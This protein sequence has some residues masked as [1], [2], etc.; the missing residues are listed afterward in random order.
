MTAWILFYFSS[1]I[2]HLYAGL[3][4]AGLSGGF[5]EAPVLTYVAEVTQ[6][7]FRGMLSATGSTFSILGVFS[8]VKKNKQNNK[9][10]IFT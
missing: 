1:N 3:C 6:P 2:Y 7:R 8:M 4:F 10:T 9:K 5:L